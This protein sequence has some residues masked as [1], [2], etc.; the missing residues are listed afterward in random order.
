MSEEICSGECQPVRNIIPAK[1]YYMW[2][3]V[4]DTVKYWF[5]KRP[6]SNYIKHAKRELQA[7]GY[8]LD[9]KEEDPNKWIVENLLELL[10]VFGKQDHSGFSAPYCVSMFEKLASFKPLSPITCVDNEWNDDSFGGDMFQNMRLSSVFK[11]SKDGIPYYINAIVFVDQNNNS[12]TG[13]VEDIG[14]S[15]YIR[16]PFEPK[17]FYIDVIGTEVNKDTDEPEEGS[18]WWKSVI[19]DRSQLDKVFDYYNKMEVKK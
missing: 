10:E 16:L 14:S 9:Q 5:V 4:R 12:F 19:K 8:N 17:S 1:V 3:N 18:D 13:N 6:D 11:K 7:I 15:Q 2:Y